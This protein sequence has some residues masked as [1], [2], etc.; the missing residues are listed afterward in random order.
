MG[1]SKRLS[2]L[3]MILIAILISGVVVAAGAIVYFEKTQT[4]KYQGPG[5]PITN[6]YPESL[7]GVGAWFAVPMEINATTSQSYWVN[8]T[9]GAETGIIYGIMNSS[10]YQNLTSNSSINFI[11]SEEGNAAT[12]SYTGIGPQTLYGV[13]LNTN[14]ATVGAYMVIQVFVQ[15]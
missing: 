11:Q 8:L 5:L 9:G 6:S 15:Q 3:M 2:P 10:E 13:M 14:N 4:G 12:L 1:L 7:S